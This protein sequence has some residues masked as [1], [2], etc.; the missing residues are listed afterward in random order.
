M[1]A[2]PTAYAKCCGEHEIPASKNVPISGLRQTCICD[3]LIINVQEICKERA[4]KWEARLQCRHQ[5]SSEKVAWSQAPKGK[6]S[7]E[8]GT[9]EP[10]TVESRGHGQWTPELSRTLVCA[11]VSYLLVTFVLDTR[12]RVRPKGIRCSLWNQK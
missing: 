4:E 7:Q 2:L 1:P 9:S 12:N 8:E 10:G 6:A 5:R 11:G 3:K